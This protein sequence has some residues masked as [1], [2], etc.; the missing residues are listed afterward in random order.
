MEFSVL[1]HF[2]YSQLPPI[3]AKVSMPFGDLARLIFERDP[4]LQSRETLK[5][6]DALLVAKDAAV[7]AAREIEVSEGG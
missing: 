4:E 2:G 7:R 5:S 1:D 3:L 6:L